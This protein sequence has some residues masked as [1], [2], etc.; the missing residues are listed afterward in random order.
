VRTH[1]SDDYLWLPL[2]VSRYV[3]GSGDSGV[4]DEPVL[5]LEG[6]AVDHPMRIEQRIGRVDRIGQDHVVDV[7][8]LFAEGTV[9]ERVLDVLERRINIF[10]QTVGGLDPIL[11]DAARSIAKAL[12][13]RGDVRDAAL[14][15]FAQPSRRA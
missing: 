7:F 9:E 13:S 1:C 11:G 14:A 6:R 12:Q 5:F 3:L 8:N 15:K 4:L 2:A 10:E